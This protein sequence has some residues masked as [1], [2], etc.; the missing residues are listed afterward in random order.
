MQTDRTTGSLNSVAP[1]SP[2]CWPPACCAGARHGWCLLCAGLWIERQ[3]DQQA[4]SH[5]LT[6][7]SSCADPAQ[8]PDT[9]GV[10]FVPAFGGLLAP[11]WEEDARGALLGMT[12]QSTCV[13]SKELQH[14]GKDQ[15]FRKDHSTKCRLGIMYVC[16]CALDVLP[17]AIQG[18]STPMACSWDLARADRPSSAPVFRMAGGGSLDKTFSDSRQLQGRWLPACCAGVHMTE[19]ECV[20]PACCATTGLQPLPRGATWSGPCW[21]PSASRPVKFSRQ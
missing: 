8:V 11:H 2:V 15:G 17:V 7:P 19:R 6:V 10:Y 5:S 12:G 14:A 20:P 3:P 4:Q 21:R 16:L 13:N 18:G 9:G 1:S